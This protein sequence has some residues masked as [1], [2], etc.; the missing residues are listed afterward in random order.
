MNLNY[1]ELDQDSAL[2]V[3]EALANKKEMKKIELNGWIQALLE[4]SM[5]FIHR[6]FLSVGNAFGEEGIELLRESLEA[7]GL[8]DLLGSLSD[9]EGGE[10]EEEED[11]E[12]EEEEEEEGAE[13]EHGESEGGKDSVVGREE[14]DLR[15][16]EP[17]PIPKTDTVSPK[18]EQNMTVSK[19]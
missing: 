5:Q 17:L 6:T 7:K 10:S 12:Q 3:A 19:P 9:D 1:G 4:I 8:V 15:S 13:E 16:E 18:I 14:S 11:E 2:E